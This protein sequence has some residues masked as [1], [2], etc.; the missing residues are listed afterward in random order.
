[1]QRSHE[2][3]ELRVKER[4]AELSQANLQL[5]RE[6]HERKLAQ[7]DLA[8]ARDKAVDALRLK[9]QLLANVS[10]DA[11]TPLAVIFLYADLLR[12]QAYGETNAK[13]REALAKIKTS[14]DE[15]VGFVG[16]LLAAARLEART[17]RPHYS[18][19]TLKDHLLDCVEAHRALAERKGLCLN[20]SMAPDIPATVV[21]DA[22]KMKR[23]IANLVDNAIKFTRQGE[24]VIAAARPDAKTWTNTVTDTGAGIPQAALP[25]IFDPF[26]QVDRSA[27]REAN[28]GI[29]LGLSIVRQ[30]TELLGGTVTVNSIVGKGSTFMVGFPLM[31][32]VPAQSAQE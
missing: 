29:G 32:V 27:T 23:I 1:L 31:P 8:D 12:Q 4:T 15:L 14:A 26:W 21:T 25:K 30:F 24:I 10:H 17:A 9:T 28:R 7:H 11:R 16:N 18:E 13:Q 22:D 6:V 3:L 19:V 20:L 5:Q 2:N